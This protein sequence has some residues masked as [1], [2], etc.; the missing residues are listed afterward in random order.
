MLG[1]DA[2]MDGLLAWTLKYARGA[3]LRHFLVCQW[4]RLCTHAEESL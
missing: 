2:T 4:V 3:G 1:H